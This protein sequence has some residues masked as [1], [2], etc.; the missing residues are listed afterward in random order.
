MVE[1]SPAQTPV[2]KTR[3][4]VVD[5]SAAQRRLT[6]LHLQKWGYDVAEAADG[7]LALD[8]LKRDQFDIVISDWMMPNKDGPTLCADWRAEDED[9]YTY[10]VLVT[11]KS[12]KADIAKGLEAGADDF[13]TKPFD[14]SELHA[15]LNAG[16]RIVSMDQEIKRKSI[17]VSA[18]Y[19]E[20]QNVHAAVERDLREAGELQQSLVPKRDQQIDQG[21]LC[22]LLESCGHI[23]GD[24]VGSY[25]ISDHRIVVYSIDVSGHGISSA[26]LTARLAAQL[27]S[28]DLTNH[29]GYKI[30]SDGVPI[31][32]L[33]SE[34]AAT[35]NERMLG[36]LKTE[37]YFTMGLVD[38]D[39]ETNTGTFVQAGHPAPV[40]F[41]PDC[42]PTFLGDGGAPIGLI[43]GIGFEDEQIT[44]QPGESL[45]LYS[46]G[47]VEAENP[48]GIQFEE[49]RIAD[50]LAAQKG[51]VTAELLSDLV[52]AVRAHAGE[53][54][55][56][57]DVSAALLVYDKSQ[58]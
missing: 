4:L 34:I 18:A 6:L 11:S 15:R 31:P 24:L 28:S 12:D 54:P 33:P 10:F 19:E 25:W 30:G 8:A 35:L 2:P 55:L 14:A 44:I 29:V 26:L 22:F 47:V 49:E 36:E 56:S 32:R 45:L 58:P 46:D 42:K 51:P 1:Q 21:R 52:W 38:F 9:Y 50:F 27:N 43:D 57:D 23:G 7:Q 53:R 48:A 20:L 16:I 40:L 17:E 37:H 39:F 41:G 5:D 13:L 3:I